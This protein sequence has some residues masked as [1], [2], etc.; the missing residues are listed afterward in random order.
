MQK[1]PSPSRLGVFCY[2]RGVG[3][4]HHAQWRGSSPVEPLAQSAWNRSMR[5]RVGT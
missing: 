2:D 3:N 1:T 5:G 4:R